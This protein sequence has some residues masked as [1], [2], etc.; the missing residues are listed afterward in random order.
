[1]ASPGS[2]LARLECSA[3]SAGPEAA[4]AVLQGSSGFTD[5]PPQAGLPSTLPHAL[6]PLAA[7]ALLSPG[8][9]KAGLSGPCSTS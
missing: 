4:L 7:A 5:S 3:P 9:A 1:M 2:M 8:P 6:S